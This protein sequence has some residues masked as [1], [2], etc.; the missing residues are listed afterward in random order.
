[1][2][3]HCRDAQADRRVTRATGEWA[4]KLV[5]H[6]SKS[7]EPCFDCLFCSGAESLITDHTPN[8]HEYLMS[9][10]LGYRPSDRLRG[11]G[12]VWL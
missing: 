2:P 10:G 5:A 8:I 6:P 12:S 4:Q 11:A 9:P 7:L 3:T 1:M